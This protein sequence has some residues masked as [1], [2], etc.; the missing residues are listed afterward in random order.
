MHQ[1]Y[2]GP[3]VQIIVAGCGDTL[4]SNL[5]MNEVPIDSLIVLDSYGAIGRYMKSQLDTPTVSEETARLL[6]A[7]TE[8]PYVLA[9][10]ADKEDVYIYTSLPDKNQQQSITEY[11]TRYHPT[12]KDKKITEFIINRLFEVFQVE[13]NIMT[14]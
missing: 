3:P 1:K 5:R 12:V 10:V 9:A 11:L 7:S 6:V 8:Y 14:T 4:L 13:E 2:N